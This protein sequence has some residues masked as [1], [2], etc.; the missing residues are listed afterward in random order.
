MDGAARSQLAGFG[1][2]GS[3]SRDSVCLRQAECQR[4]GRRELRA[5]DPVVRYRDREHR[6]VDRRDQRRH[7]AR[8]AAEA[9]RDA[10]TYGWFWQ[11]RELPDAPRVALSVSPARRPRFPGRPQELSRPGVP[12][13]H[14][15]ALAGQHR[16]LRRHAR[17]ARARLRGARA[18]GRRGARA[19]AGSTSTAPSAPRPAASSTKS[20]ARRTS[21][22]SAPPRSATSGRA[23][24]GSRPRCST[25]PNDEETN[26]IREKTRLAKGVLLLAA[27]RKLQGARVERAP[28]AEGSGPGAARSAEP[29]G[30]R[31][32][33][34][35]LHAQQHRRVR[36]ARRRAAPA[37]R[38]RAGAPRATSRSSRTA[39]SKASRATS[40]SS[41]RN[42][43]ARTR[44]RRAS[45]WPRST[46][47]PRPA[48]GQPPAG[49]QPTESQGELEVVPGEEADEAAAPRR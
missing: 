1:R 38:R 2:A 22:R 35:Q 39:C 44:S 31:A 25:A 47:A 27:R 10:I 23:S 45:R 21:P 49:E 24:C 30:A 48:G 34:A 19:R 16:R 3:L 28:H 37:A 7:H 20:R 13:R 29:L 17:H 5:R 6:R 4:A 26:A 11:L 40:S 9:R 14:A 18:A 32:E 41:R 33:G 8:Q 43:S 12:R 36:R 46:T 15:R 42:A